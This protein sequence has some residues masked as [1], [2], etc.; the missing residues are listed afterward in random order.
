MSSGK[1]A[2]LKRK[3]QV[4]TETPEGYLV[5]HCRADRVTPY[6]VVSDPLCTELVVACVEEMK[7]CGVGSPR[8]VIVS[9]FEDALP[10]EL[11]GR[12]ALIVCIG[13]SSGWM[14]DVLGRLGVGII[15]TMMLSNDRLMWSEV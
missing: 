8:P 10:D 14:K 3:A 7:R 4:P 12:N 5:G 1:F 13:S 6:L 15:K 2:I 9:G 11:V